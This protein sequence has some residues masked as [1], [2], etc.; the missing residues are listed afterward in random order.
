LPAGEPPRPL[1]KIAEC[2]AGAARGIGGAVL[3]RPAARLPGNHFT[4]PYTAEAPAGYPAL[5]HLTSP[6]RKAAAGQ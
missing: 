5:H 6:V 4:D 3:R 1:V 2:S